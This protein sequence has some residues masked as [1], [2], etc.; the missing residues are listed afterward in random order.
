M[1]LKFEQLL[2]KPFVFGEQDCYTT[3]RDF[4]SAN[5]G[6]LMPNYARPSEF[7]KHGMNMYMDRYFK[8]GFRV[9]D[10]HP[11]DYLPGDLF[12]MSISSTVANHAGVLL[13]DGRILHHLWGRLSSAD[14][15]RDLL[16]NTTMAV[17][18]HPDMV[19][20]KKNVTTDIQEVLSATLKKKLSEN[21]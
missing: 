11:S 8:N 2:G 6:F 16:R 1:S 10:C 13:E 21:S 17:L 20:E 3:V 5:A 7:W 4:Y 15:Y 19:L 9:T 14:P 18:R 12:I